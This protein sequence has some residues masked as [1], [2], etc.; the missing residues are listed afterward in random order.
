L[1]LSVL[2]ARGDPITYPFHLS[3]CLLASTS[4]LTNSDSNEDATSHTH[5]ISN[6]KAHSN[7]HEAAEAN[8][9]GCPLAH[10]NPSTEGDAHSTNVPDSET[11]AHANAGGTRTS[12]RL[13]SES[14][15]ASRGV[16]LR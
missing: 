2:C 11:P 12:G 7:A 14:V 5:T 10:P 16:P 4:R 8:S 3:S 15:Q 9:Q 13:A 6:G 1:R